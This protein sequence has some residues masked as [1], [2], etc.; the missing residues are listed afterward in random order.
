MEGKPARPVSPTPAAPMAVTGA[1][2]EVGVAG[3]QPEEVV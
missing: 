3:P 2:E 1:G